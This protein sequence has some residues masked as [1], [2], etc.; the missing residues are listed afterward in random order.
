MSDIYATLKMASNALGVLERQLQ[1]QPDSVRALV[2]YGAMLIRLNRAADALPVLDKAL[3]LAPQDEAGLMN[4]GLANL[5][6][7]RLDAAEQDFQTLLNTA[8]SAYT[9]N[10][11]YQLAE[12]YWRKKNRKAARQLYADFLKEAPAHA[13]QVPFVKERLQRLESGAP[14]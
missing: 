10:A 5:G 2:N 14:L 12:V 7:D 3:K 11:K 8:R 6:A 13:S 4:R 1:A 9:L